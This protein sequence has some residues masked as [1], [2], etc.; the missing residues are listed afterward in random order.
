MATVAA[1]GLTTE[2]LVCGIDDSVM[3]RK[4]RGGRAV[5]PGWRREREK[6]PLARQVRPPLTGSGGSALLLGGHVG[7]V[8]G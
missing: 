5:S 3:P 1:T 4:L 7:R 6:S 2:T 8:L